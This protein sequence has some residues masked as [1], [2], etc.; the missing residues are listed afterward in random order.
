[1][2]KDITVTITE[3]ISEELLEKYYKQ[4]WNAL[5]DQFGNENLK[6]F[7]IE[8]CKDEQKNLMTKKQV[9]D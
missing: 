2:K 1:M 7:Y 6:E 8:L 3:E 4:L 5:K 9:D